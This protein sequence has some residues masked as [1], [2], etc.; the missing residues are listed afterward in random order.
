MR[1]ESQTS[2]DQPNPHEIFF[3]GAALYQW[4]V[5]KNL[6]LQSYSG[7][8]LKGSPVCEHVSFHNSLRQQA[9]GRFYL[10]P[11]MLNVGFSWA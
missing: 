11:K 9:P 5:M 4:S 8:T 1:L 6:K 7:R 10:Q 2:V 3:E